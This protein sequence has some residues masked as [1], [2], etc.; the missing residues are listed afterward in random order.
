MRCEDLKERRQYA[1]D[2]THIANTGGKVVHV[3]ILGLME[4]IRRKRVCFSPA[5]GWRHL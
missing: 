1:L 4:F 2:S 5:G 3:G